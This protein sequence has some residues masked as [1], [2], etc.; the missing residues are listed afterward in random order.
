MKSKK[1]IFKWIYLVWVAILA[2]L[3]AAALLYVSGLLE[4]Y[5]TAQPERQ[6]REAMAQL[7]EDAASRA[8]GALAR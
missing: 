1:G 4:D 7:V 5:E 3:V 8:V 2:A 6:V